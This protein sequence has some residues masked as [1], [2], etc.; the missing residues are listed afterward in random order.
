VHYMLLDVPSKLE[1]ERL[2]L[3]PYKPG[4]GRWLHAIFQ[5]NKS[6]LAD[7]IEGVKAGLGLDLTNSAEAEIF[8]RQLRAD[9]EARKRFIFGVWDK[10]SGNYIGDIWIERQEKASF[11]LLGRPTALSSEVQTALLRICQESLTNARKHAGA[12]EVIVTLVFGPDS[13]GLDVKDNGKGFDPSAPHEAGIQGG[14]GLT[15]MEQR[16]RSL[17]GNLAVKSEKGKGTLVEVRMPT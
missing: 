5:E 10:V 6:H 17:G 14:F 13:V 8:V 9:W 16:A 1:T 7:S 2:L 12:T 11:T 3:R 15:G 4:D